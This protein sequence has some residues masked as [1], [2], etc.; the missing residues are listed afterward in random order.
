M[1]SP[2]WHPSRGCSLC[3]LWRSLRS[4]CVAGIRT[5]MDREVAVLAALDDPPNNPFIDVVQGSQ[6]TQ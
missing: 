1:L 2:E 4:F 6:R 3:A 5:G